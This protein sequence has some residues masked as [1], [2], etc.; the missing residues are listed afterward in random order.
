MK[1]CK[2]PE[3]SLPPD[4][5]SQKIL[6]LCDFDGTI[7]TIDTVNRLVREHLATPE[8]RFHVKRYMRGEIGSREV[9]AAVASLMRISQPMLDQFVAAHAALDPYFPEFLTWAKECGIDVKVVS[10][11]FDATILTLFRDHSICDIEI[12]ANKLVFLDDQKVA[13]ESPFF[14][15]S[16]GTCGTCKLGILRKFRDEY[17]KIILI[18]DGESDRHI[19]READ[20]VVALKDLFLYCAKM[21]IA[22]LR[23]DGF[24]EIPRLLTRRVRAVTFDMD[25]TLLDS[26]EAI[27]EAFNFMFAKLGYPPMTVEEVARKTSISLMDFMKSFVRPDEMERGIKIFRDYYD[28]IFLEKSSLAPGAEET[29][30]ALNGNLLKGIVTNKRGRYAR[31]LADHFGLARHMERIIGAEDGFKAKP[32]AEMFD[33]FMQSVGVSRDETIYVG[34]AP[35]DIEAA[36]RAGIDAFAIANSIFPAEELALCR[37]RRVL[38]NIGELATAIRPLI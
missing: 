2:L 6:I 27:A 36:R 16:C 23:V 18:G 17:Q 8:W 32:S 19:A 15:E 38:T 10:D 28:S 3:S 21:G 4:S 34:D 33:E 9:Y 26:L 31:V 30:K 24:Q 11:G 1:S 13:I 35:L 22:A 5:T 12:F 20:M 37:P 14:N 25:G 29:L 7:S